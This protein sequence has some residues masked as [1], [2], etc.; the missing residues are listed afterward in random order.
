MKTILLVEDHPNLGALYQEELSEAGYHTLRAASGDEAG[1]HMKG[2]HLDLVVIEPSAPGMDVMKGLLESSPDLP[3]IIN[4]AADRPREIFDGLH[5]AAFV[6]KSGDLSE[7]L[8]QIQQVLDKP[9]TRR[10]D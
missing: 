4:T 5:S 7:L 6:P 3:I 10:F 2:H 1:Q 9:K 8:L